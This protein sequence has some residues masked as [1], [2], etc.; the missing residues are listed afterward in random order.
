M[1][2]IAP[3]ARAGVVVL[4]NSD[5]AGA[6]ELA[7]QLLEIV[8]GLP[9]DDH[10]EITLDPKFYDAHMNYAALLSRVDRNNEALEQYQ[11]VAARDRD[12]APGQ[13]GLGTM[14]FRAGNQGKVPAYHQQ[15]VDPL[16]HYTLLEPNDCKGWSAL[17]RNYYYMKMPDDAFTAMQKAEQ[18]CV[19]GN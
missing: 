2:L 14:L 16:K 1:I 17:G 15:A 12:F 11:L 19:G 8:L 9:P 13:L 3:D 4:I 6:S 18:L 5:A 7:S 10:K